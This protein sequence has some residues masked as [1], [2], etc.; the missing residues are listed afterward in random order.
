VFKRDI[1]CKPVVVTAD[2]DH[3]TFEATDRWI[4]EAAACQLEAMIDVGRLE[5]D[6]DD[7]CIF[8]DAPVADD[9]DEEEET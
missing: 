6:V 8:T 7:L 5:A 9:E 1:D 2:S 3:A 4:A